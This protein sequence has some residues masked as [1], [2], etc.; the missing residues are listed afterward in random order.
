MQAE[1]HEPS[2]ELHAVSM[3]DLTR[4][5]LALAA[6]FS[7]DQAASHLNPEAPAAEA[8]VSC[9]KAL[10]SINRRVAEEVPGPSDTP[11][12]TA[13]ALH[14]E[15]VRPEGGSETRPASNTRNESGKC[16]ETGQASGTKPIAM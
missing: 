16:S 3:A 6:L 5:V 7:D 1:F 8:I 10:A 9:T 15:A 2:S 12:C 11:R 14:S 4:E 13:A